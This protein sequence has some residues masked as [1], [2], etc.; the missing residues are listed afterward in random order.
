MLRPMNWLYLALLAPFLTAIV[1]LF[2]D[3]LLQHV[4]K[5]ARSG[6]IVTGLFSAVPALAIVLLG[7]N[8]HSL[9]T[10]LILLTLA[11][12]FLALVAIYYYFRGLEL[13]DPSVVAALFSLTPAIMP[14][15]AHY[16]V[17][18]RLSVRA[19]VGFTIVL[20]AGFTYSL[21]D[22]KKFKV[23]KALLP[24][25]A[26]SLLFDAASLSG[27][28]A[29]ER[30][31]F[32]SAYLFISLG[33]VLAGL[34]FFGV[35]QFSKSR[36]SLAKVYQKTSAKILLLLVLVEFIGMA[37]ELVYNK[38]LSLGPLSLINVLENTQP[39]FVLL[40]AASLYPFYP[41][42]FREAESGRVRIKVFLGLVLIGGI[43]IAIG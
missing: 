6:I 43:Y 27:K 11:S 26:A 13:D 37:A 16:L 14:F 22:I 31:D 41:K 24:I 23:S 39:L 2:D 35:G 30:V 42:Y 20:L 38:A 34:C 19:C 33:M 10:H 17:G 3:N 25:L 29:Y 8:S 5:S 7:L 9:P 1:S 4:Y 12:G 28:Y 36:V 15:L 18:E 21:S 40:I 32:Y